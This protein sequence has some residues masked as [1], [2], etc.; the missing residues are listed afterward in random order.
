MPS[1]SQPSAREAGH[2]KEARMT[3]SFKPT[4]IDYS[5]HTADAKRLRAEA[6][7]QYIGGFGRAAA[8]PL[9]SAGVRV[10][11]LSVTVGAVVAFSAFMLASASRTDARQAALTTECLS[12]APWR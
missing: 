9:R 7:D 3:D 12:V 2:A 8:R 10:V 4:I 1:F 5:R 6:M 11:G